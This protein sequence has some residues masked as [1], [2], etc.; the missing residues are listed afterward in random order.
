MEVID[1]GGFGCIFRPPLDCVNRSPT[2]SSMVSKLQPEKYGKYEMKQ[3]DKLKKICKKHIPNCG[4]YFITDVQMCKPKITEELLN[5]KKCH[6]LDSKSINS[7]TKYS[8]GKYKS[9]KKIKKKIYKKLNI[10]NMPYM[11]INLHSYILNSID[12]HSRDSFTQL[13]NSIIE[14]YR[15]GISVLNKNKFYH[16]DIKTANILVDENKNLRL[17]DWGLANNIVFMHKFIFN[18]PYMY[19]L[20]TNY[21]LEQ[22]IQLKK[23]NKII[24]RQIIEPVLSNYIILIKLKTSDNYLYT[25]EILEFMFP[26]EDDSS[27]KNPSTDEI[28]PILYE[29]FI[30][31]CL[32]FNSIEEWTNTYIHNLDT[33]S[34]AIMYPDILCAIAI[35]KVDNNNIK[36]NIITFFRKYVLDCYEPINKDTFIEDLGKL[37]MMIL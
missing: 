29:H 33:V 30:Q 24:T 26:N 11:G 9:T 25:K 3:L 20:M 27:F 15:N 8:K 12:F 36:N 31:L 6:I 13:N 32:R 37:N 16:N 19:V 23:E 2:K 18:K 22:L 5:N 7:T 28:H 21:F 35:Q 4:K 1:E 14:L 34:I 10:L 17:I